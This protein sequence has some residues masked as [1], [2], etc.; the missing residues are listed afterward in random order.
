[1]T[2]HTQPNTPERHWDDAQEGD[3]CTSP[4]YQVTEAR[5][6]AY[7]ELTGDFTPVHIDE[8]YAKTTP[9]GTRVAHGLFGLSI[10]DGLKTRSDYRFLPGM[11]LGWTWDFL[12]PIKINDEL[13]VRFKVTRAARKQEPAGLGHRDPAFRADQP[14]RR[15]GAKGR[16]PPDDPASA[17]GLLMVPMQ[18]R[19]LEGFRV[20]DYSHFLAGPYVGRCLAA[21]GAEVIKVERP[22]TG[23][24][25]RQHA[26]FVG[27]HSGYFLQ[28][29]MG[30]KGLS[31][32]TKD[33]RGRALMEKLCDSADVFVEN[34]R[35]GALART[36][37]RLRGARHAQPGAGVLLDLGLRPHR[38][39]RAPRRLRPDRRSQERHHADGRRRRATRRR[40]CASR[41]ATCT[42]A[43]TRWRRSMRRCSAASSP[44]SGQHI[45]MALYDTLFSMHEYA[46]QCYTMSGGK[47][48]P[49]QT[50]HDM[51]N[52]T[53]LRRVPRRRRRP[54]DRGAGRRCLE[55]L[56]DADRGH[57]GPAGYRQPMPACTA[58]PG[59]M[60]TGSRSSRWSSPGWP[61]RE[62]AEIL[63]ALDEIDV[64]C[65][66]VQRIDEVHGRSADRRRAA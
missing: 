8:E 28:L 2:P 58:R 9:F 45:D 21:L 11:S 12:L 13:R 62:V 16:A 20:V 10:A 30:K 64:P 24:A 25:G 27:D 55:A 34:Y 48:V 5:I 15:G 66:K 39:G 41:S 63:G 31:V 1:M 47:E 59:A 38:P 54:G 37:P 52:S 53:P 50:G 46:V 17:G 36:G 57:G 40:C 65:A 49:V 6:N 51:P 42:P 22:G 33:P 44:A 26:W 7:A 18:S 43:S 35:P 14:A 4:S 60:R 23:D 29:N 61:S 3:E 32:N 19:P 56:R